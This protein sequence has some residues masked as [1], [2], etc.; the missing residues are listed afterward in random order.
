MSMEAFPSTLLY[1]FGYCAIFAK[2]V[3]PA[4]LLARASGG[5]TRPVGLSRTEAEII[6]ERGED[7]DEEDLPDQDLEDL[8]AAGMFD[9]GPLLRAGSHGDW[10]F[11]IEPEGPY[12]ADDE[13][14]KAVSKGTVALAMRESASGSSWIA[15]AENGDILSS[16]DP[17][18]PDQDYGTQPRVLEERTGHREA[19]RAGQRA[20]AFPNAVRK[21]QQELGCI[22]PPEADAGRLLAIRIA[23]SY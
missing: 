1:E 9:D 14:L 6:I 17:L 22:I 10:S 3:S 13:I 23:G 8:H 4:A 2:D 19:I 18:F 16:F 20:D 15:Y 21:I 12:L 7:V 5:E 11:M